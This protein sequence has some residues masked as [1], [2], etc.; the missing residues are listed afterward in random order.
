MRK[1]H[2][3]QRHGGE[4]GIVNTSDVQAQCFEVWKLPF[5][6]CFQNRGDPLPIHVLE[7]EVEAADGGEPSAGDG[8]G[9]SGAFL[10]LTVLDPLDLCST[11]DEV[12]SAS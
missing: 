8:V 3:S 6:K 9:E 10:G 4:N 11:G 7:V 12:A 1:G 2:Q 5:D